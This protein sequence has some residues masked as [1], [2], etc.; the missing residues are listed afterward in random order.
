MG[1][2]EAYAA[3]NQVMLDHADLLVTVW[4]GEPA[5]GLGGTAE[6]VAQV[7]ARGKPVVW[8]GAEPPHGISLLDPDGAGEPAQWWAQLV[9]ELTQRSSTG[10]D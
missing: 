6:I 10:S 3:A 5:R 2:G 8:I 1:D 9:A 4:D 7:Q